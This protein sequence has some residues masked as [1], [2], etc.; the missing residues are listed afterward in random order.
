M[1]RLY[2]FDVHQDISFQ[3]GFNLNWD[4]QLVLINLEVYLLL[5]SI[6]FPSHLADPFALV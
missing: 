3:A 6:I 4:C 5:L 1:N 2:L